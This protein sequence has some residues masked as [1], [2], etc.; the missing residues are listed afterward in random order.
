LNGCSGDIFEYHFAGPALDYTF[1]LPEGLCEGKV[2]FQL[3]AANRSGSPS[4][5]VASETEIL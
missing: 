3:Y 5:L 1:V 4:Q 2:L